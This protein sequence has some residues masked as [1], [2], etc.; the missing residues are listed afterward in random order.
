MMMVMMLLIDGPKHWITDGFA[1][2]LVDKLLKEGG[3][4]VFIL[5]KKQLQIIKEK[6]NRGGTK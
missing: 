6:L 2:F 4:I 3:W 1:F 5:T